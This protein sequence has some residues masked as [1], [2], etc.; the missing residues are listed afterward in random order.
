MK[1]L[2]DENFPPTL[3]SYLQKRR[4]DVKRIQR[5]L[6]G[7]SDSAVLEKALKESRVIVSFDKDYLRSEKVE[8]Q[9]STMILDFP[10]VKPEEIIPFMDEI[11]NVIIR[12]KRKKKHFIVCYS[13]DGL[14]TIV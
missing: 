10:N 11:I 3:I 14:E 2:A 4:H 12:L 8:T 13:K 9:V 6:R 1:L 7:V 5:D